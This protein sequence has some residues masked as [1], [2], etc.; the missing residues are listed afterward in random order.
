MYRSI[1]LQSS[2]CRGLTWPV[3]PPVYPAGGQRIGRILCRTLHP[4]NSQFINLIGQCIAIE[5]AAPPT[6]KGRRFPLRLANEYTLPFFSPGLPALPPYSFSAKKRGSVGRKR[7]KMMAG[8]KRR[9]KNPASSPGDPSERFQPLERF[10]GNTA[11]HLARFSRGGA[12]YAV[13]RRERACLSGSMIS[14]R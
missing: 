7:A 14:H 9:G 11:D 13:I 8:A 2:I 12:L 1:L 5:I 10:F 4:R 3:S 6:A